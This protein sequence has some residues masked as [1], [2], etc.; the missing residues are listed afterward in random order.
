MEGCMTEQLRLKLDKTKEPWFVCIGT[1]L[2]MLDSIAPRIGSKL[3]ALGYNVTGTLEH[4]FMAKNMIERI[5]KELVKLDFN[6]Y[7]FIFVDVTVDYEEKEEE[8]KIYK[9][10]LMP[11]SGAGKVLPHF[12]DWFIG[13]NIAEHNITQAEFIFKMLDDKYGEEKVLRLVDLCVEQIRKAI[14]HERTN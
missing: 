12:G 14:E 1:S 9:R 13:I 8:I 3:E 2:S 4:N 5:T 7:Q 11:G 10:P 6:K